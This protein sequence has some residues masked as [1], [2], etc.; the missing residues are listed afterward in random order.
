MKNDNSA[1]KKFDYSWIIIAICFLSICISLGFCS[2][3][4]TLY[5][6]A[7]TDALNFK[8]S[9]FSISDTFRYV[10]TAIMNLFLGSLIAKFGIKKL[11]CFGYICLLGFSSI[12]SVTDQLYM[13]YI[14]GAL[15]GLG[16]TFAGT[17]MMSVV[18]NRWCHKNKGTITGLI[19]S[20]NG[21]GGAVAV[22]IISPLIFNG[23]P[24]GYRISYRVVTAIL[25]VMFLLIVIF[26]REKPKNAQISDAPI[27]KKK[28]R[29][30]GWIGMD[31]KEAIKKPYFYLALLCIMFTGMSLQGLG[32][33]SFPH[34]YDM[35][36]DVGFVATL[37]TIS[38]LILMGTKFSTGYL[39]DRFGMKIT[40]NICL[41]S[42]FLSLIGLVLV[43]NTPIGRAIAAVRIVFAAIALP[44][45]TIMLPLYA[46]ELFGNKSFNKIIGFFTAINTAGYAMGAP[47]ANLFF[48]IFGNYNI[49]FI[50]FAALM[51]FVTITMQFV[52][53]D[54]NRDKKLILEA[55]ELETIESVK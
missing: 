51:L 13:F 23:D 7:I 49:P 20:A 30:T 42:S 47:L 43:S 17:S 15:L 31:Y 28:A 52:L 26:F 24:F 55:A 53:R 29:G 21:L 46:S 5:L 19:F 40:M 41:F 2:S 35:G 16:L 3:G 33:I 44:L 11:M 36:I 18:V 27:G 34:M 9:A 1:T 38:S 14:S 6:T 39:Y 25:A 12:R 48:D 4:S 32:G 37:S 45:E 22:Q 50:L 54:A 10:T 8:R